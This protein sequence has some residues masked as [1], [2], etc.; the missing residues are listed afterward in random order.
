MSNKLAHELEPVEVRIRSRLQLLVGCTAILSGA[1]AASWSGHSAS[2]SIVSA[3]GQHTNNLAMLLAFLPSVMFLAAV[4]P[5]EL[6]SSEAR[7]FILPLL[8]ASDLSGIHVFITTVQAYTADRSE[9]ASTSPEKRMC[10]HIHY[11]LCAF[12]MY[13]GVVYPTAC[14]L[15]IGGLRNSWPVLRRGLVVDACAFYSAIG[16][17]WCFGE[18]R[19]PPGDAPLHVA[20]LGRPAIGLLT[21]TLL[22]PQRR[23]G[24]SRWAV[25]AGLFHVHINLASVGEFSRRGMA[26]LVSRSGRD[27]FGYTRLDAPV[28]E[29]SVQDP[30]SGHSGGGGSHHTSKLAKSTQWVEHAG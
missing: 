10:L 3:L 29:S 9:A 27:N 30:L 23:E 18:E 12:F 26:E 7:R 25:A 5:K 21:A 16:L 13:W 24:I 4:F 15:R 28:S 1:Y 14:F 22:T 17:L 8:L 2:S 11:G 19:Y 6:D 20:L